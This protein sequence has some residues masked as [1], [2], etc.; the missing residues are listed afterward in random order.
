MKDKNKLYSIIQ[1]VLKIKK[2]DKNINKLKFGDKNWDSLKH[3]NLILEIEKNFKIKFENSEII[4]IL[5]I[6]ELVNL[7]EEK[8]DE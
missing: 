8:L 7:V 3:L 1:K 5:S 4:K 6:Q 2:I